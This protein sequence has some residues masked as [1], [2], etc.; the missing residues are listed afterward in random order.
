MMYG[1]APN[2]G[3]GG[4]EKMTLE[5]LNETV[6]QLGSKMKESEASIRAEMEERMGKEM[7]AKQVGEFSPFVNLQTQSGFQK[8]LQE[9]HEQE[10]LKNEKELHA[11]KSSIHQQLSDERAEFEEEKV[12]LETIIKQLKDK[13]TRTRFGKLED[14]DDG[15]GLMG[16]VQAADVE[17]RNA[18]AIAAITAKFEQ[19][20]EAMKKSLT[21]DKE[22]ER[23][24]MESRLEKA[25]SQ[26]S[27]L[28]DALKQEHQL[29]EVRDHELKSL[30]SQELKSLNSQKSHPLSNLL[31]HAVEVSKKKPKQP[32][33]IVA[34][35][36]KPAVASQEHHIDATDVA[37]AA[38][39]AIVAASLGTM[40][41]SFLG[42]GESTVPSKARE[43]EVTPI[44][45]VSPPAQEITVAKVKSIEIVPKDKSGSGS[46]GSSS[47]SSTG[48][49]SSSSSSDDKPLSALVGK[50][51]EVKPAADEKSFGD[52]SDD[53]DAPLSKKIAAKVPEQQPPTIQAAK[54][55]TAPEST[56]TRD[57][58]VISKKPQ[59]SPPQAQVNR[60]LDPL[61]W[62]EALALMESNQCENRTFDESDVY[63]F[64]IRFQKD[65]ITSKDAKVPLYKETRVYLD[66]KI[67][68]AAR[69]NFKPKPKPVATEPLKDGGTRR[70]S[71]TKLQV[72]DKESKKRP[73]SFPPPIIT[74]PGVKPPPKKAA[75]APPSNN[76]SLNLDVILESKSKEASMKSSKSSVDKRKSSDVSVVVDKSIEITP[77]PAPSPE[78]KNWMQS[79]GASAKNI[80]QLFKPPQGAMGSSSL[81]DLFSGNTSKNNG[82]EADIDEHTSVSDSSSESSDS[83]TSDG[84]DDETSDNQT[85]SVSV[86]KEESSS[87]VQ[88]AVKTSEKQSEGKRRSFENNQEYPSDMMTG[89]SDDPTTPQ[90]VTVMSVEKETAEPKPTIRAVQTLQVPSR[91]LSAQKPSEDSFDVSELSDDISSDSRATGSNSQMARKSNG[92][93]AAS[94]LKPLSRSSSVK[95]ASSQSVNFNLKDNAPVENIFKKT[96]FGSLPTVAVAVKPGLNADTEISEFLSEF[97]DSDDSRDRTPTLPVTSKLVKESPSMQK[98][99]F[100]QNKRMWMYVGGGTALVGL[101]YGTHLE[102]VP[103]SGRTRFMDMTKADEEAMGLQ[104]YN[105]IMQEYK[106]RLVPQNH[107]TSMWVAKVARNIIKVAGINDVDWEIHLIDHPQKNAFVIPG[108]KVFVFS[109]ILP[110]VQN[111]DGLAAVLGH[112]VAHQV[113]RHSAEKMSA[114]KIV[115]LGQVLVSFIFD[116]GYLAR[117]LSDIGL[118]R[119]FSRM[120]EEEAD[121]I[122][123]QLMAQACYDPD[124]AVGM[125][126]RMKSMDTDPSVSQFLSTHPS[127]DNRIQKITEWLPEARRVRENSDCHQ[128]LPLF[129]LFNRSA[130][131]GHTH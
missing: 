19:Q 122:G 93:L 127:H 3:A 76:K 114:M 11:L 79:M 53:D 78:K 130:F 68:D 70:G 131:G 129:S 61:N 39:A 14:D 66:S 43:I 110:V 23:R 6:K 49:T 47:G 16:P 80:G 118:M 21:Q 15:R 120:C 125:W 100:Y 107:P 99:P 46:S 83:A 2:G 37:A 128:T 97:T 50:K 60:K 9:H 22:K 108:G 32:K 90:S 38:S 36:P 20:V 81:K 56:K 62:K 24:E 86:S 94:A 63:F 101:Y 73:A 44:Q 57:I 13:N 112:E 64:K 59:P 26:I 54:P 67:A 33:P 119:P 29:N 8:Q 103:I 1:S 48:S 58:E 10:R 7:E 5:N 113:A 109:G 17:K 98:T 77:A 18:E 25:T 102:T 35:P 85:H 27:T 124:A 95:R 111:E 28:R 12:A 71:I 106:N 89:Y 30:M 45:P 40:V 126:K 72:S 51:V 87:A 34:S 91:P 75:P 121:F 117:I 115:F 4:D 41:A 105:E 31:H 123:L 104:A 96:A 55:S 116:A 92:E 52:T 65:A 82:K 74:K 69:Q 84:S 88:P 42:G